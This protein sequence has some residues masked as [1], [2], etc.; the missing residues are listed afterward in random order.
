[1]RR[2]GEIEMRRTILGFIAV[3]ASGCAALA[4]GTERWPVK[5][6]T[7]RDATKV[8]TLPQMITIAQLRSTRAPAN[9]NSRRSARFAPT[10]LTTFQ[11]KGILRVIKKEA[12]Q[13]YH[14]VITDP[15]NPRITMIVESPDPRCATGSQFL[16]NITSVRTMLDQTLRLNQIFAAVSRS[17]PSIPVTVTGVAFF[18]V[19]HG[20]EGVAPNGIELHPILMID[21]QH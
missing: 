16:D 1:M 14:L 5:V 8:V 4:C 20:Q 13:D 2:K 9:P 17:E 15:T 10:E 6:G 12:D 21:F 19:L 7:D 11:V 3:L 18:D